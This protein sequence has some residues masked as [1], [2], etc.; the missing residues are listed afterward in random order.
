MPAAREGAAWLCRPRAPHSF[1]QVGIG[2]LVP[3]FE[4]AVLSMDIGERA[5]AVVPPE[6]GYGPL[7]APPRVP[8][9]ATLHFDVELISAQDAPVR[10][11]HTVRVVTEE[12]GAGK[13]R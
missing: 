6:D 10:S 1:S 13:S 5:K 2:L 8:K 9:S 11:L 12:A 4:H 7:G 3:G